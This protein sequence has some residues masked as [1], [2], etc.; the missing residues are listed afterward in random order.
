MCSWF[1][2]TVVLNNFYNERYSLKPP[3]YI[4][5][6][7]VQVIII[8]SNQ[9]SFVGLVFVYKEPIVYKEPLG[10]MYYYTNL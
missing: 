7:M 10:Y 3:I 5:V 2:C 8:Q 4:I 6:K 1:L 9:L